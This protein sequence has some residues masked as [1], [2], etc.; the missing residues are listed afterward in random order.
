MWTYRNLIVPAAVADQARSICVAL[1][2]EGQS[3]LFTTPLSP[4]GAEPATHYISSGL[5]E[6]QFAGLLP[7]WGDVEGEWTELSAGLPETILQLLE[8]QGYTPLPTL[9][10]LQALLSQCDITEQEPFVALERL[11]LK[12]VQPAEVV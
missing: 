9:T 5:I 12:L 4:T 7:L 8:Q 2:G 6:D 11:A 10:E 3:G 1:A